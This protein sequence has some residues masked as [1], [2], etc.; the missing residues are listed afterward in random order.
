LSEHKKAGVVILYMRLA[1][2]TE[3]EGSLEEYDGKA[4]DG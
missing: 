2:T 1:E 3:E 4:V